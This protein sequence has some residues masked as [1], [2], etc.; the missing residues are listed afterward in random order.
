MRS[1]WIAVGAFSAAVAVLLGA[2]GAHGLKAHVSEADLEIWKT[3]VLYHAIHSLALVLFGLFQE[4]RRT[5]S[6]P[7]A[8][9]LAGIVIFSLTLY[10]IGIGGPGWL[11]AITPIG[12]LALVAGW[13]LFGIQAVRSGNVPRGP[14]ET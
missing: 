2:F 10:G 4:R 1:P 9:F 14:G 7:G 11:G 6:A 5:S 12:G 13:V 8:L 3:G